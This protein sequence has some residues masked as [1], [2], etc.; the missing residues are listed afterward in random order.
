MFHINFYKPKNNILAK[1][2]E[3]YYFISENKDVKNTVYWTYPN[4]FVVLTCNKNIDV[5]I[6]DHKVYIQTSGFHNI[7]TSIVP[8][9]TKP[10]QINYKELVDEVTIYFKPLGINH[11][12]SNTSQLFSKN[13]NVDF[14]LF[15][16]FED[17]MNEVFHL[18][19]EEK[20]IVLENYLLSKLQKREFHLLEDI[21]ASVENNIPIQ[22]I[23]NHHLI[24]RQY[25]NRI[26]KK[27]VGKSIS[28]YRKIHRF[29][30]S[31][32]QYKNSKNFTELSHDNYYDQAHFTRIFKELTEIK[33]NTFFKNVDTENKNIWLFI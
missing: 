18:S 9:Y 12:T 3:G 26:F 6:D 1:Y 23:A 4:N 16:D 33:P 27:N 22:E 31:I 17:K 14:N 30:E 10:I 7:L 28:E 21:I 8:K 19:L 20:I 32:T 24:S 5:K 25:L 15:P 11:F 2:I 13:I 29:R